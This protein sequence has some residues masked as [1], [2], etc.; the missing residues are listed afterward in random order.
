MLDPC[1]IE[2]VE[3]VKRHSL[4]SVFRKRKDTRRQSMPPMDLVGRM[5]HSLSRCSSLPPG[6]SVTSVFPGIGR[7]STDMARPK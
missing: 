2:N 4:M 5:R 7:A 6:M 3:S 1:F